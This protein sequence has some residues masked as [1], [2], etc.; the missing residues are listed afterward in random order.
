M[1]CEIKEKKEE[2]D[3]GDLILYKSDKA[4]ISYNNDGSD[5]YRRCLIIFKNLKEKSIELLDVDR[6]E[7]IASYGCLHYLYIS[8]RYVNML[9]KSKDLILTNSIEK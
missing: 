3:L 8:D 5:E 6:M 9:C 1:R 7:I 4:N 2:I